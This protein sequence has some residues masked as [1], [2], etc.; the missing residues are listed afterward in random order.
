MKKLTAII[1]SAALIAALAGCAQ[2]SA[3]VNPVGFDAAK[4]AALNAAGVAEADA[5][6]EDV[7]LK[8]YNGNQYYEI[9]FEVGEGEGVVHGHGGKNRGQNSVHVAA[10][11]KRD[12]EHGEN[13]HSGD[14]LLHAEHVLQEQADGKGKNKKHCS[15]K[16]VLPSGFRPF[17]RGTFLRSVFI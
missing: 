4:A 10:C 8:E 2:Q 9:E 6:F 1:L 15:G 3:N 13:E 11:A 12:E 17:H 5:R 16:A 14:M 7:S